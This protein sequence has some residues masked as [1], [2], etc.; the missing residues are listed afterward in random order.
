M[1]IACICIIW[2]ISFKP[3]IKYRHDWI[4]HV[5]TGGNDLDLQSRV[6]RKLEKV[7]SFSCKVAVVEWWLQRKPVNMVNNVTSFS[8]CFS[9]S[10]NPVTLHEGQ[11]HS[12]QFQALQFSD[13]C[14][15]IKFERNCFIGVRM[16]ANVFYTIIYIKYSPSDISPVK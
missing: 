5:D 11:G 8:V 16:Q 1:E 14:H 12:N 4:L 9:C 10:L 6:V 3:G 7:Q 13:V 2:L 15:Y